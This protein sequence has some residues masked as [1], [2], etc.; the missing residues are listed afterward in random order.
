VGEGGGGAL[1]INDEVVVVVVVVVVV[2]AAKAVLEKQEGGEEE[3]GGEKSFISEEIHPF[4]TPLETEN[5]R[6]LQCAN[7]GITCHCLHC[8]KG[9]SENTPCFVLDA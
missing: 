6:C 7:S 2:A 5:G 4:L 1:I 9:C 8:K 3:E